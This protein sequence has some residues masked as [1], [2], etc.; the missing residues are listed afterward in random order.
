MPKSM[1][2]KKEL[3]ELLREQIVHEDTLVNHRLNWLLLSQA[4]LFAVFTSIL[5]SDKKIDIVL[6]NWI[7]FAV[8]ASGIFINISAFIGLRAA[9]V[10]LKNLRETWYE[11]NGKEELGKK[12][13]NGFPKITWTGK[14]SQKAITTATATP[15]VILTAWSIIAFVVS[16]FPSIL[17]LHWAIRIAITINYVNWALSMYLATRRN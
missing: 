14:P 1:L 8:A 6:E 3:F 10:S 17:L 13:F 2:S 16:P 5:T 9:Y 7:L 12:I 11:A 4:F 15:F